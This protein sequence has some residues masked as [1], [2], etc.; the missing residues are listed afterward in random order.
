MAQNPPLPPMRIYVSSTSEDL[1]MFR[2]EVIAAIRHLDEGRGVY[3]VK[4]MEDYSSQDALPVDKCRQ[5]VA[6][7]HVYIGLFAWRYGFIPDGFDLSITELEYR[8]ALGRGLTVLPFVLADDVPWL[9]KFIDD[10][11]KKEKLKRLRDEL[12]K[13]RLCSFFTAAEGL[14]R[15]VVTSIAKLEW[16]PKPPQFDHDP[17]KPPDD[18]PDVP[19]SAVAVSK[20]GLP[21]W[22]SP[23]PRWPP[24]RFSREAS[25]KCDDL[26]DTSASVE[27]NW[28]NFASKRTNSVSLRS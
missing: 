7:C 25:D 23:S 18:R 8:E 22:P 3:L 28:R 24:V 9:P 11:P 2:H 21:P 1:K 17:E 13:S 6:S 19:S 15:H 27:R 14:A 26:R 4:A 10:G 12:M 5:D 20:P 16:P